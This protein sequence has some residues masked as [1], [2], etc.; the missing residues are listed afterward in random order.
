VF[1]RE[2]LAGAVAL[3]VVGGFAAVAL[4]QQQAGQTSFRSRI[5]LVPVDFRVVDATGKPVTGLV[6][7]DFTVLE[8]GVQQTIAHFA[9]HALTPETP[10]PG[11]RPQFRQAA[12]SAQVAPQNHRIFLIVLGRGRLQE[13][14]KGLDALLA[15]VR[16]QLLPQDHVA[17]LAFNRATDFTTNHESVA[18]T[19]ERFRAGHEKV[20]AAIAHQFDGNSLQGLY[21]SREIA[22]ATQ[23]LIDD[24]LQGPGAEAPRRLPPAAITDATRLAKDAQRDAE[25]LQEAEIAVSHGDLMTPF[26][27]TRL[28][29]AE[30]FDVSL[31]EYVSGSIRADQDLTNLYT[32]IEYMRYLQGEKHLIL[33]TQ[34]G[35]VLPRLEDDLGIAAMANDARVVL[36]TIQT[37]GIPGPAPPSLVGLTLPLSTQQRQLTERGPGPSG[38]QLFAL[39]TLK[40]VSQ[41]TGGVSSTTDYAERGLARI[42]TITRSGYLL[43]YYPTNANWNGKYRRIE[44]KVNRTGATV[45]FRH[46]YYGRDALVPLDRRAF[47]TFNR[48]AAAGYADRELR[49]IPVAATTAFDDGKNARTA[50]ELLVAIKVDLSR[51]P[52]RTENGRHVASLDVAVF[53]ADEKEALIGELRRTIDLRL[54]DGSYER[55]LKDG[56]SLSG[57]VPLKG[58]VRYLKAIVYDYA[59]DRLGS[60]IVKIR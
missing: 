3:M 40:T 8:D 13:P 18:L 26:D 22:P 46:G 43:G 32:G 50:K 9:E 5:T 38:T 29:D 17:V 12:E 41:L 57:R 28:R 55:V 15:F 54:S 27:A 58:R 52:F 23:R 1:Q 2:R 19:L 51:V 37:G 20:E 11:A 25:V 49:D 14:A 44:V 56:V 45:L 48:L 36:D 33:V 53:C 34:H 42:D 59:S 16:R 10:Q 30:R 60:A 7:A 47:L 39:T 31:G 4:S 21:G 35:V 6:A 24:M